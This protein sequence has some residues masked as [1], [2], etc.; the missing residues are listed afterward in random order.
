ISPRATAPNDV[1]LW[2]SCIVNLLVRRTPRV[3]SRVQCKSGATALARA[4]SDPKSATPA[5]IRRDA[6][7]GNRRSLRGRFSGQTL[8]GSVAAFADP[9]PLAFRP[10]RTSSRVPPPMDR[11]AATLLAIE[12]DTSS[13][14]GAL[15]L[16]LVAEY[17]ASTRDGARQV[18]TPRSAGELAARF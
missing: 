9:L 4:I 2:A 12:E 14:S 17:F 5:R 8:P 10:Q 1:P 18:S 7:A 3:S 13:A 16:D 11:S 15:F 6:P